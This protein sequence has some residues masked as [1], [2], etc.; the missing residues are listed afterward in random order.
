[1][2]MKTILFLGG[3]GAMCDAVERAKYKGY[4]TIVI[5]YY[6]NSPAKRIAD[7]SY[8]VS[9]TDA[10]VVLTIAKENHIDGVFTGYSDANLLPARIIADE[11]NL[12]F[13]ANREQI[14]T[15]TNKLLFKQTCRKFAIPVVPEY[16]L[17]ETMSESDLSQIR[18]PVII[19]PSDSW[20]SKG[21]SICQNEDELCKATKYALQ[22]SR[23]KKVIVEKYMATYPDVC[24]YFNIQNGV[25]SLAAMCERDMNQV[26]K[27]KAMQPN[28]LFFP[29]RFIPLYYEQLETKLHNMIEGLGIKQGTMFMQCFVHDGVLMPFE[30]G[31]RLCGAQEYILC[32]AENQIN[33][34]DMLLDYAITGRFE[35]WDAAACN[36]PMFQHTDVIL[37]A[38]LKPGKIARIIGLD[39]LNAMPELLKLVQFYHEGDEIPTSAMGTL[40]QTF[41]RIFLQGKNPQHLLRLIDHV[42]KTLVVLNDKEENMLLP[43]YDC[44]KANVLREMLNYQED[45]A[46]E[47]IR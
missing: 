33:S 30:M 8:L 9:T 7:K 23:N 2:S 34:L 36:K 10:D 37:L 20:A 24:M 19:K 4:R 16:Q 38:L 43:G 42:Q 35:G 40:N 46:N 17:D 41:A 12:P 15:T 44:S 3:T 32:S 6:S 18:Y 47:T 22:Y 13:Y 29:C 26:Q 28:A 39:E 11:L 1:M 14:L 27:G 21:V 31:Y 45:S 5:D 25:L